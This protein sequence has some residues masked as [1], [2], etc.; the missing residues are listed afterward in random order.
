[1][2]YN[3]RTEEGVNKYSEY[4]GWDRMEEKGEK[5]VN[6]QW[7]IM[8]G[9]IIRV[10][11]QAHYERDDNPTNTNNNTLHFTQ[12]NMLTIYIPHVMLCYNISH[13]RHFFF[14]YMT[15]TPHSQYLNLHLEKLN[16]MSKNK[17]SKHTCN[18]CMCCILHVNVVHCIDCR[19][20]E[21]KATQRAKR[22]KERE[23]QES[24]G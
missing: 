3:R 11:F 16:V 8:I 12:N 19:K 20:L 17:E 5:V 24:E 4:K 23:R 10:R 21:R 22:K 9:M 13:Y 7:S 15:P 6:G 2:L 14:I 1:M 18:V